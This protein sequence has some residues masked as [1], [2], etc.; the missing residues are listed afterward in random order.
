MV[1]YAEAVFIDRIDPTFSL[2]IQSF[3]TLVLLRTMD[4]VEFVRKCVKDN[5]TEVT[6][7]AAEP[8]DAFYRFSS[9]LQFSDI[10]ASVFAESVNIM[11]ADKVIGKFS[12][13]VKVVEET[14][15]FNGKEQK[16]YIKVRFKI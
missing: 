1:Q 14:F 15:L 10:T 5:S 13:A 9:E 6:I 16:Q 8:N 4:E 3:V 11:S 12:V 2:K 7:V